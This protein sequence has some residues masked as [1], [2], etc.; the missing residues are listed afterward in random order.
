MNRKSLAAEVGTEYGIQS[1]GLAYQGVVIK[2]LDCCVYFIF[3][4]KV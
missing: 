1:N 2:S 4:I 3:H